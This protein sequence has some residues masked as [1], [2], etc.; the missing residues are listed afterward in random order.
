M[1]ASSTEAIMTK[2]ETNTPKAA[3]TPEEIK[4]ARSAE[5]AARKA[6]MAPGTLSLAA[7]RMVDEVVVKTGRR[8]KK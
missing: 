4:A 5:W 3:P 2:T 7:S 8:I 6:A 1:M